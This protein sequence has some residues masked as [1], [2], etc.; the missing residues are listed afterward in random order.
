MLDGAKALNKAVSD[1]FGK[2]A[3]I[4]RCQ[5]YKKRNVLSRLPDS[6]QDNVG[7]AISAAYLEFDYK[8]AKKQL[9]NL[10]ASLESRYPAAACVR[11]ITNWK[12]GEMILRHMAAGFLEAEKSFRRITGYRELPFLVSALEKEIASLENSYPL[13]A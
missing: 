2:C 5:V 11:R 3:A 7:L 13:F 9:L 10:A 4:Q 1:T 6:E 8:P 12:D